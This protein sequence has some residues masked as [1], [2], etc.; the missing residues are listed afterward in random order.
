[1]NARTRTEKRTADTFFTPI[2]TS[3]FSVSV[4]LSTGCP[5]LKQRNEQQR[6]D[7]PSF[8][9]SYHR[10]ERPAYRRDE[11]HGATDEAA[12]EM[13]LRRESKE[14]NYYIITNWRLTI[15]AEGIWCQQKRLKKRGIFRVLKS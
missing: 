2:P 8:L 1:V 12:E 13:L 4:L 11:D 9:W 15:S 6:V 7:H 5:D 3:S 14:C 10:R